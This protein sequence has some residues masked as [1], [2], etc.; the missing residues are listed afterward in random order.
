MLYQLLDWFFV[1]FHTLLIAFNLFGWIR[2][3]WLRYNLI[4][5]LLTGGSWIFL[6]LFYGLGYC[7]F[8][9]WH[10]M[11]LAK[12]GKYPDTNSYVAYLFNRIIG[13]EMTDSFA[14]ALTLWVYLGAFGVSVTLNIKQVFISNKKS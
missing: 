13:I 12:L 14:D 5:L 8:T 3:A 7:P 10:W 4:T 6:G 9:D 2:K 1:A 11:V